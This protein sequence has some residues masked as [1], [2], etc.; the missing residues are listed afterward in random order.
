ML[1]GY[2]A[3][4]KV[5]KINNTFERTQGKEEHTESANSRAYNVL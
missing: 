1:E 3:L 4:G 5:Y 2:L